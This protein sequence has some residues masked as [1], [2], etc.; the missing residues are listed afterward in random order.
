[1]QGIL[2]RLPLGYLSA[3]EALLPRWL[4]VTRLQWVVCG[5]WLLHTVEPYLRSVA[6]TSKVPRRVKSYR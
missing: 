4:F 6:T 3:L 2:I 1:M 5:A